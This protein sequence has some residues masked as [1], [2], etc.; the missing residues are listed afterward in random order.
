[1]ATRGNNRF[2]DVRADV[3]LHGFI[4][5]HGLRYSVVAI[6]ALALALQYDPEEFAHRRSRVKPCGECSPQINAKSGTGGGNLPLVQ[7][8][9]PINSMIIGKN[10]KVGDRQTTGIGN[11]DD[12]LPT[13]SA[14]H[15]HAV[16]IAENTIGRKENNGGNGTGAQEEL[17][18]TQNATGVMGVCTNATVRRLLPIETERLMGFPDNHTRIPWRGKP[19]EQC[20]D[21]PRYKACG[22]SMCVNVMRWI[23]MR[24]EY[25]ER[26]MNSKAR[27]EE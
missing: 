14:A 7:E 1:M 9:F 3:Q 22:N 27:G 18:Y 2:N 20:P 23:G 10:V 15:H 11:N 24:I 25:V 26:R 21:G 12:P 6:R 16:A 13:I 19:E 4:E 8:C 5:H 17:T